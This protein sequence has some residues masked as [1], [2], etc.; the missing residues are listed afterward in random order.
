MD[1]GRRQANLDDFWTFCVD[2]AGLPLH[3][4]PHREMVEFY[5]DPDSTNKM[6]LVPRECW[7]TT[8]GAVAYPLW[9]CLRAFFL[10]D[11]PA[12]R[13]IIDSATCELSETAV[14]SIADIAEFSPSF[15]SVFGDLY[16][17]ENA[18]GRRVN[19]RKGKTFSFAYR[20]EAAPLI[21]EPNFTP[22]GLGAE[23]TGRHCEILIFD[24]LVTNRNYRTAD[25]REKVW[26]HYRLMQAILTSDAEGRKTEQLVNGTRYHDADC[27]GRIIK[28]D[29]ERI[30]EGDPPIFTKMIRA[31]HHNGELFF[32]GEPGKPGGLSEELLKEKQASMM[33]LYWAQYENDPSKETAPFKIGW[34]HW[35]P[36]SQFPELYRVRLTIDP[37]I[38]DEQVSRGDYTCMGVGGW[39]RWH[40]PH[41]LDVLMRKDLTPGL[42]ITEMLNMARRNAVESVLIED[43][44]SLTGMEI[45]WRREMQ[46]IGYHV[47]VKLMKM[48]PHQGK[49]SR[50]VE[51][52]EYGERGGIVIAEEIPER[53]KVEI[54]DEWT[55]APFS[56]NDDFM[57]MAYL[58]TQMLPLGFA[59]ISGPHEARKVNGEPRTPEEIAMSIHERRGLF[60]T[61]AATFP[62]IPSLRGEDPPQSEE[63]EL[64]RADLVGE[65]EAATR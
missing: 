50:W 8:I 14:K 38:K 52:Q 4:K 34:L 12:F 64:W 39:D 20:L 28:R 13:V 3:E 54:E 5:S 11:N 47:P 57:D 53:V 21:R 1:E 49:E 16:E 31:S 43:D 55:R 22:S 6:M 17:R 2:A 23:K 26:E 44:G 10:E 25:Q 15:R 35:K 45:L 24:D 51:L 18:K 61:L 9:R 32:P 48:N 62:D 30:A 56:T 63:G 60:G 37:A 29:E 46:R 41:L 42:F 27:Y 65:M 33:G 58:Q 7:K 40:V 19:G 59:D 36:K